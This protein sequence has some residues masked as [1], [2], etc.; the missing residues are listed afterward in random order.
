MNGWDVEVLNRNTSHS[1]TLRTARRFATHTQTHTRCKNTAQSSR[2]AERR[3][4]LATTALT[5][6]ARACEVRETPEKKK[7]NKKMPALS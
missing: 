6:V 7:K 2:V 4:K 5:R 1:L 3:H